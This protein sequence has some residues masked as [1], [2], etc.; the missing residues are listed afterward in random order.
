MSAVCHKLCGDVHPCQGSECSSDTRA[1]LSLKPG[2]S[3]VSWCMPLVVQSESCTTLQPGI[4]FEVVDGVSA[5]YAVHSV[6][7][8]V[9][10]MRLQNGC[11]ACKVSD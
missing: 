1:R 7:S 5:G 3:N 10:L 9:Q 4:V 8:Q 6:T 11:A 2:M